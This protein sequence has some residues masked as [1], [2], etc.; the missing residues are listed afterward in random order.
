MKRIFFV[1]ALL[2]VGLSV[3]AQTVQ[4]VV[5]LKNGS[6]V[7]G[8]IIEQVP[9]ESLK[10]QTADGS[11][12]VYK[13]EEVEKMTKEVVSRKKELSETAD[14]GSEEDEEKEENEGKRTFRP[15]G[16]RGFA[17]LDG[18]FKIG[19]DFY[20]DNPDLTSTG[21]FGVSTSHGFQTCP[22]FFVGGG[23][24]MHYHFGWEK[25]FVPIFG[26][27]HVNFI[28]ARCSPFFDF[29]GGY[30]AV[31]GHGGYVN[32]SIGF[33]VMFTPHIGLN[34]SLGYT[35]QRAEFYETSLSYSYY[36]G[37][38]FNTDYYYEA[39]HFFGFKLGLEF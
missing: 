22:F 34:F 32:T 37:T 15:R 7:R 35:M 9:N 20:P 11:I 33:N 23:I 30:A 28:N 18:A 25:L 36:S 1:F 3:S 26:N 16:Y 5:Y 27:I 6:I 38:T 19:E 24:A 29:K 10:I 13:L 39:S 14:E 12:F 4:E 2:I 17:E 21:F 8:V 31:D